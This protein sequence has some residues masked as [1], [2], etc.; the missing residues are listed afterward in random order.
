MGHLL[1][2]IR[3]I[4][5]A[6]ILHEQRNGKLRV[7]CRLR[8]GA[9]ASAQN[10]QIQPPGKQQCKQN[11]YGHLCPVTCGLGYVAGFSGLGL[12]AK[13]FNTAAVVEND[14]AL[15]MNL[16]LAAGLLCINAT[17]HSPGNTIATRW[18]S[19]SQAVASSGQSSADVLT[20]RAPQ[21]L[22]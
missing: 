3:M 14:T 4:L 21:C 1:A 22:T 6:E 9:A 12:T 7:Q 15:A 10:T 16:G 17:A 13:G 5:S 11:S 19:S 20:V 8:L 2:V 18:A